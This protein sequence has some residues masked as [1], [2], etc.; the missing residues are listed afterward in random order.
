MTRIESGILQSAKI[1]LSPNFDDRPN[2][3][4]ICGIVLHNISLPPGEFGG[5]YIDDLFLNRLD[6]TAHPYFE[7]L[8]G[9]HVSSHLLIRR[10]GELVQFVPF[11]KRA[12][13]AGDSL[14]QGRTRCNDFTVGIELEGDDENPFTDKQ[15]QQLVQCI[16]SLT[17]HY[18]GLSPD[19]ITGHEDIAPGRKTDPG[20]FFDWQR[21]HQL[22]ADN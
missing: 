1:S 11:H 3:D 22:L 14:W 16:H 6:T 18:P 13:H 5:T 12:W 19:R 2:E 8:A 10:G 7:Q 4:D 17:L 9:L 20:P 15:Y 21:L